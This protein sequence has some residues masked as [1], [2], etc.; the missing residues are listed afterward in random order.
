MVDMDLEAAALVVCT[1]GDDTPAPRGS[2]WITGLA[3]DVDPVMKPVSGQRFAEPLGDRPE[4]G[5]APSA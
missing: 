5:P 2:D 3:V 4:E 1:G